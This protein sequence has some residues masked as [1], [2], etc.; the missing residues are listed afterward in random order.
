MYTWCFLCTL[1]FFPAQGQLGDKGEV[2]ENGKE[3]EEKTKNGHG[4][5]KVKEKTQVEIE[6]EMTKWTEKE[7]DI[8]TDI[9]ITTSKDETS[10][11]EIEV[12]FKVNEQKGELNMIENL[13]N[14]TKETR[15]EIQK[16]NLEEDMIRLVVATPGLQG[17]KGQVELT[18]LGGQTLPVIGEFAE[19]TFP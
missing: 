16:I 5:D 3:I 8:V 18:F 11:T 6:E 17:T 10:M 19:M 7:I 4:A 13:V 12:K 1:T 2:K 9:M 14:Q 15:T